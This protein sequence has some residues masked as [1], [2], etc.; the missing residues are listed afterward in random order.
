MKI[1]SIIVTK[2]FKYLWLKK[3]S[4]VDLSVHCA[5]S[6]VGKYD[7]RIKSSTKELNDIPLDDGIWYLCG[8]AKPYVWANNFH[9]A[10]VS[11][12]NST[13]AISYNGI[14]IEVEGAKMLPINEDSID[15][16]LPQS[17]RKEY[18]TCRNWQFANFLKSSDMLS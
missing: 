3:I 12:E 15:W 10:F 4:G 1:K 9:F 7:T 14:S 16:D 13:A 5:K 18:S 6:L 11:C 17:K 2:P 8:V